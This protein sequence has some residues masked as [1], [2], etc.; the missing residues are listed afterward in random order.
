[1]KQFAFIVLTTILVLALLV[2]AFAQ[3]EKKEPR[4]SPNAA[5][6]Q[7]IGFTDVAV[8]YCRPGV[9]GRVIWGDLVPYD[10]VW[11]T[12]A[13]EATTI[14]FSDD[15][16]IEGQK[17]AKGK[18]GVFT[19]PTKTT[20]TVIFNK[21]AQQWGAYQYKPEDDVLRVTVTPKEGAFQERM[22]FTFDNLSDKSAQLV[23]SW[24]K[25]QVPVKI[26]VTLPQ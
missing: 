13:N 25:L 17:L 3:Q 12:G 26:E 18:Y 20:W 19:I 5:V 11:R 14:T 4:P 10:K 1:M 21:T 2:P 15:V 22:L 8:T 7:T 24:E 23:L 16:M 6:S 9:K